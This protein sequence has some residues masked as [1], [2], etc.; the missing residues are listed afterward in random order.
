MIKHTKLQN[1]L[2]LIT[3]KIQETQA[4]TIFIIVK[5]G[6]RNETQNI[7]GLAHFQEHMFFKGGDRFKNSKEVSLAIDSVGGIFNAFTAKEYVGYYVKVDKSHL[8]LAIDLLSDMMLN[9][10]FEDFEIEKERGVILE[11]FAMYQDTPMYQVGWEFESLLFGD[12]PLGWDQIGIPETIKSLRKE[13]FQYFRNT[14]YQ[15]ENLAI[16]I[17]GSFDEKEVSE[18]TQK[19]FTLKNNNKIPETL[20]FTKP[21][22]PKRICVKNKKTE[23]SH[24]VI[25][26]YG[27]PY[28]HKNSW[29][30]TIL[31]IILGGNMSS[32]LFLKIREEKGFAY[33]I[34]TSSDQ[35]SDTGS[36]YARCGV[37]INKCEE[38]I[39][40]IIEEFN[41]IK[42]FGIT[43]DE[44]KNAKEYAK[45]QMTLAYEDSEH[46]ANSIGRRFFFE[47]EL[48]EL[49]ERKSK[50][51]QVNLEDVN[52]IA[53]DIFDQKLF[54]SII[55]PHKEEDF[56]HLI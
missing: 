8:K 12:T 39:K 56:L 9:A 53:K 11:E 51:D 24:L 3:K 10:K 14:W 38:S 31:S 37:N 16:C 47:N 26:T 52:N 4:V 15:P 17:T 32:R 46:V 50:I 6:S 18:L 20:V 41:K 1:G 44:L 25:G 23:Q 7:R 19:Y 36:F 28:T 43:E 34:R 33:Y 40:L 49:D 30:S 45:G 35:F 29:A 27:L 13:D 48:L 5:T 22:H 2:N 54:L 42:D 21:E 55:G